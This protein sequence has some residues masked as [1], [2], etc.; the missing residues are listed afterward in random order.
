MFDCSCQSPPYSDVSVVKVP[1]FSRTGFRYGLKCPVCRAYS[2][3]T[4][5]ELLPR[6]IVFIFLCSAIIFISH[7]VEHGYSVA[8]AL[9][10]YLGSLASLS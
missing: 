10:N 5:R 1:R 3:L 9:F 2:P 7:E 8:L 6:L 4:V